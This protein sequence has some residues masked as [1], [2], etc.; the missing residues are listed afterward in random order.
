MYH[1]LPEKFPVEVGWASREEPS[2]EVLLSLSEIVKNMKNR[3]YGFRTSNGDENLIRDLDAPKC[4]CG[5]VINLVIWEA[6]HWDMIIRGSRSNFKVGKFIRVRNAIAKVDGSVWCKSTYICDVLHLHF[7]SH[8]HPFYYHGKSFTS[9]C[10][11][12]Y[13]SCT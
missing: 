9:K 1:R 12:I 8:Q 13:N 2:E 3:H 11:H 6:A 7:C 5:K 4:L 10:Q